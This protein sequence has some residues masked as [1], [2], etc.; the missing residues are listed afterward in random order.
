[1][2]CQLNANENSLSD[3]E[4]GDFITACML[5]QGKL[6]WVKSRRYKTAN[7]KIERQRKDT[8]ETT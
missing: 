7:I 5:V 6:L 3:Y 4:E 2:Q 8:E 1:V